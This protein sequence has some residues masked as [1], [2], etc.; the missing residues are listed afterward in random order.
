ME[1]VKAT[2]GLPDTGTE[3][4]GLEPRHYESQVHSGGSGSAA[5]PSAGTADSTPDPDAVYH[6]SGSAA[7]AEAAGRG[8][9]KRPSRIRRPSDSGSSGSRSRAG[10]SASRP[11]SSSSDDQ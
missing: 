5:T 10:T 9:V 4:A 11:A 1:S 2:P 3:S 7:D 8:P 6:V